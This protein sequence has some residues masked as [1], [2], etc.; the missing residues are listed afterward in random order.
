MTTERG[1]T[2][3]EGLH[4]PVDD[5]D[6]EVRILEYLK[7]SDD[8]SDITAEVKYN[9]Q[10]IKRKLAKVKDIIAENR[11][12]RLTVGE[13]KSRAVAAKVSDSDYRLF[14]GLK[15]LSELSLCLEECD[16]YEECFR[17]LSSDWTFREVLTMISEHPNTDITAQIVSDL[18][19]IIEDDGDGERITVKHAELGKCFAEVRLPDLLA[20]FLEKNPEDPDSSAACLTILIGLFDYSAE[21]YNVLVRSSEL[22]LKI[23]ELATISNANDVTIVNQYAMEYLATLLTNIGT[24]KLLLEFCQAGTSSEIDIIDW[25]LVRLSRFRKMDFHSVSPEG[26]EYVEN[27]VQLLSFLIST[28]PLCNRKFLDNEGVELMLILI[29]TEMKWQVKTGFKILDFGTTNADF[30]SASVKS[31]IL[32]PL[33]NHINFKRAASSLNVFLFGI[34]EKLFRYLAFDSDERLRLLNKLI[35]KDYRNLRKIIRFKKRKLE[36]GDQEEDE[37]NNILAWTAADVLTSPEKIKELFKEED[38]N[39]KSDLEEPLKITIQISRES[40]TEENIEIL[41]IL[42]NLVHALQERYDL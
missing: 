20:T 22:N 29:S 2:T 9:L 42:E 6:T 39:L 19:D 21:V 15:E 24:E 26:K 32:K 34:I 1:L 25:L 17:Y 37:V 13:E 35:D 10:W 23:I 18:R 27:A 8:T 41:E 12:T 38:M 40:A 28:F 33:F 16:D 5:A 7:N 14:Q 3:E 31:A 11:E 4:Q 36:E 30:A